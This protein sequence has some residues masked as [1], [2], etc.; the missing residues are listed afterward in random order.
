MK[1]AW[2]FF[3]LLALSL[4]TGARGQDSGKP[5][6][7]SMGPVSQFPLSLCHPAAPPQV[8]PVTVS[9]RIQ[10]SKLLSSVKPAYPPGSKG[11]GKIILDVTVN[12]EG[13]VCSIRF[14]RCPAPLREA[15]RAAVC[16]WRY[17]PTYLWID[18]QRTPVPVKTVVE[19]SY[20]FGFHV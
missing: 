18:L 20:A 3:L 19:I 2:G 6:G 13:A 16:Q 1:R 9:P 4:P 15:V 12:E 14:I 17:K 7:R 11:A 10:K 8:P 5:A